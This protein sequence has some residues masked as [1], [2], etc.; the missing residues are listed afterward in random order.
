M[1]V[2]IV[3]TFGTTVEIIGST[4]HAPNADIKSDYPRGPI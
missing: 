3:D 2:N 1:N 4:P